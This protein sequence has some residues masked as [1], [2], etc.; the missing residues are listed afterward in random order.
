MI[1]WGFG[2]KMKSWKWISKLAV[3]VTKPGRGLPGAPPGKTPP[4]IGNGWGKWAESLLSLTRTGAMR[5]DNNIPPPA[6]NPC[7]IVSMFDFLNF[8][9]KILQYSVQASVHS[10]GYLEGG[11]P[12]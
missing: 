11:T 1:E 10:G 3:G 2:I 8:K 5:E 9:R 7:T 6:R 12:K 4:G